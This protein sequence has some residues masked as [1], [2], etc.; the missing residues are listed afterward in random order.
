MT[1]QELMDWYKNNKAIM[2]QEAFELQ[3]YLKVAVPAR[4]YEKMDKD[5]SEYPEIFGRKRFIQ[6]LNLL[7]QL[8]TGE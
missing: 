6:H 4:F 2:P 3:H 7:H 8:V 5:I 1:S